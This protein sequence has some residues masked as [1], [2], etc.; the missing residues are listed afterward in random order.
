[1]A[2]FWAA[3]LALCL[4]TGCGGTSDSAQPGTGPSDIPPPDLSKRPWGAG[5][6][7]LSA[8]KSGDVKRAYGQYSASARGRVSE[9]TFESELKSYRVNNG[10]ELARVQVLT[11]LVRGDR[12]RVVLGV[13]DDIKNGWVLYYKKDLDG[14][15]KLESSAGGPFGAPELEKDWDL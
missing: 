9:Y 13:G 15:W 8:V 3:A 7:F 11:E 5:Q 12:A 4:L 1:M 2:R 14:N 10:K 6:Q